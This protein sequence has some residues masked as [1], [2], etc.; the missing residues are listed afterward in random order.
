VLNSPAGTA[1]KRA[2]Y[3]LLEPSPELRLSEWA[4]QNIVLP[5]GSRVRAG[6]GTGR[7]G[8]AGHLKSARIGFTK[9]LT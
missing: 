2:L 9:S 1:L 5:E 4:E 6:T 8:R 7:S 3:G